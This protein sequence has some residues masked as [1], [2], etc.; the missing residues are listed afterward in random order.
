MFAKR[1][2][3]ILRSFRVTSRAS[4]VP[5]TFACAVTI[6]SVG[7]PLGAEALD[8]RFTKRDVV[9][10]LRANAPN[11]LRCLC[12]QS[13]YEHGQ[14]RALAARHDDADQDVECL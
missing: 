11:G 6:P 14:F 3:S 5:P 8:A 4:R 1:T 7:E 12:Q 10:H 2:N 9:L 13:L